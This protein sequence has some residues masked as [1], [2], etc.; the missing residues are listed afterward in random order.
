[1]FGIFNCYCYSCYYGTIPQ[2]RMKTNYNN[3]HGMKQILGGIQSAGF[4]D[5]GLM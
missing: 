1:M 2:L 4:L 5:S 3:V